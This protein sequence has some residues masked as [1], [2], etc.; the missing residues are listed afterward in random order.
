M[1]Y[2]HDLAGRCIAHCVRC[3]CCPYWQAP[4][5][6]AQPVAV[7]LVLVLVLVLACW[8][9]WWWWLAW[10]GDNDVERADAIPLVLD[11]LAADEQ[12]RADVVML[13]NLHP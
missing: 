8:W 13:P 6:L 11:R 3:C 4:A 7:A 10:R 9:W 12:A 5:P 2:A 1:D